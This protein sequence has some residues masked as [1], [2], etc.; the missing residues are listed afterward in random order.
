MARYLGDFQKN[1]HLFPGKVRSDD[2]SWRFLEKK[3]LRRLRLHLCSTA[4][5]GETTEK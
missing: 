3:V 4:L 5:R 2:D 1:I